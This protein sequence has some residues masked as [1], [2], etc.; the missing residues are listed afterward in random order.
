MSTCT[1]VLGESGQG[2]SYAL[3]NLDPARTL[4]IQTVRKDLPFRWRDAGWGYLEAGKTGGNIYVTDRPVD[5]VTAMA[6]T[7]RPIIV[8]DDFAYCMSN[9]FFR[10]ATETGY[11]KFTEIQGSAW[12][13]LTGMVTL[14]ETTRV[15]IMAHVD[16]KEDG[17]QRMKTIGKMLDEKDTPEGR[18]TVVLR[19]LY[20][21]GEYRFSTST[22]GLDPVKSPPGMFE[23]RLIDNDLAEVDAALCA[24][25]GIPA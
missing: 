11:Q 10:R 7:Q 16:T 18:F 8:I 17:R 9:E 19:A 2:K 1:L 6:R 4:L 21:D 22:N 20:V 24:Y 3:R 15:Y 13:V 12:S 14:P 25:Y 5:M 23:G